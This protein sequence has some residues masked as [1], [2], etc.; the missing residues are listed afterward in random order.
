MR[1]IIQINNINNILFYD[2]LSF[3]VNFHKAWSVKSKLFGSQ[4]AGSFQSS[5]G[6]L[7][8]PLFA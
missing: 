6:P 2:I 8:A 4:K 7:P 1:F 5:M 3:L